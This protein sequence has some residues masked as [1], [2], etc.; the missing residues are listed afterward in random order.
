MDVVTTNQNFYKACVAWVF[1]QTSTY[2]N[3]PNFVQA[4]C[5]NTSLDEYSTDYININSWTAS[6]SQP[7]FT[8]LQTMTLTYV[9]AA[10]NAFETI[11]LSSGNNFKMINSSNIGKSTLGTNLTMIDSFVFP[12]SKAIGVITMYVNCF[13]DIGVTFTIRLFDVTSSQVIGL[14]TGNTNTLPTL[15]QLNPTG[16]MSV[17]DSTW[18]I[19]M[20]VT[21]GTGNAYYSDTSIEFV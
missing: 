16:N 11:N 13:C 15:V 2:P 17:V 10:F 8:D 4:S 3:N 9:D 14:L 7:A 21:S 5:T 20:Q 18:E 12:G 1:N 19:Q 6:C